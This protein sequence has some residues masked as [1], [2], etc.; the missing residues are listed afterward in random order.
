MGADAATSLASYLCTARR[1]EEA[2]AWGERAVAASAGDPAARLQALIVVALSLTLAGR[3][4]EGLARLDELPAAAA[5]VPL[6]ATD[7]LVM[8][9]MCRLFTDDLTGA[10]A[11]LSVGVARLRAGVS[12][13]TP[14]SACSISAMPSTASAPGTTL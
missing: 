8:R 2:L 1:V 9:G 11:D 4:P 5:E 12:S 10:M 6:E 14:A 7:G 13:H 3:G